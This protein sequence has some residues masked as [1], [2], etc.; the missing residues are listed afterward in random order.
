MNEV[1]Y[2]ICSAHQDYEKTCQQCRVGS[3]VDEDSPP[4]I[5]DR[6]LFEED[7][8][9]WAAKIRSITLETRND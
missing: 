7:P 6:R 8:I 5:A 9:A 4:V 2:S 1:W 3:W